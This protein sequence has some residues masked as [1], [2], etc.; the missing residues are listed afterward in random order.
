[1]IDRRAFL[2]AC[3][4]ATLALPGAHGAEPDAVIRK[5]MESARKAIPTA[6]ADPERP[7]YHFHPPANWNNDPN[8]TIYYKGWHH[9]FYQF[10]P[11]GALWGHMHW[12]HARSRD[13]VNWEHLPIAIGPSEE[14]G[15]TAIFSGGAILARDGKPR[16]FY[17]SIG[18]RD[19]QQW[20][21]VPEDDDLLKLTKSP[22]N[23]VLTLAAHGALKVGDW[24]DPFLFTE[25]GQTYMVCGG[26]TSDRQRGGF[27]A[28]Q[29]YRAENAELT[30][31][32]H[33][34]PVFE[35]R[36]REIINIEC[37][38]LFKVDGKWVL[39]IS[40]HKPCEYFVGSLDLSR[41]RFVPE[42]QGI[43]DAGNDY[44]SNISV[45]DNGRT[46][47][48]LWGRTENPES[49]G[50]NSVMT[51]PRILSIGP[52]GFLRQQPA[53]EF[54][55]LRGEP[56]AVPATALGETAAELPGISGDCF[57]LEMEF[58]PAR[59]TIGI[60][61]RRSRQRKAGV[62]IG[63]SREGVLTVGTAS[64][65]IGRKDR[66]KLRIFLDKRVLEVYLDDGEAVVYG[67]VSADARREDLGVAVSAA[68]GGAQLVAGRLWPLKP[69]AFSLD[70]FRI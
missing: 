29:L 62:S 67:T 30:S 58:A 44:A 57:E 3:S 35:Y 19:P 51:I 63:I 39:I 12:G 69:A 16:L 17:T 26:N 22:A 36:N 41:P 23:P 61:L 56:A 24:R 68:G 32:K 59:G 34:G 54:E 28:V 49:K 20:M 1:M 43:L 55:V 66:Y 10:N 42:V 15:E 50:W 64:T 7:V 18:R 47:L 70:R 27:G 33:L 65:V 9:L 31:W 5:A 46:I 25:T 4:A 8:G 45:D 37:P 40:P 52:D 6:A 14:K 38:N 60:E 2:Q 21:V 11:Y 53:P 13:M 48:W